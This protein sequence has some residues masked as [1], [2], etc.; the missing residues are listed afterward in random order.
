MLLIVALVIVNIPVFLFL[1]WL[2]FD[3][4]EDAAQTFGETIVTI[5]QILFIPKIVR[6]LLEMDDEGA[7]GLVPIVGFF[8]A[9]GAIVFGE[10]WLVTRFFPS[11]ALQ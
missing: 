4:K 10:Y 2:A 6:V 9:C 8:I 1:A 7:L 11:L 3:S 5:L